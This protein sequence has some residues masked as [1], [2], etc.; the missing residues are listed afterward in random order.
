MMM[1]INMLLIL[2]ICFLL[3]GCFNNRVNEVEPIYGQNDSLDDLFLVEDTNS[4]ITDSIVFAHFNISNDQ[5]YLLKSNFSEMISSLFYY[6]RKAEIFQ[7]EINP[8]ET[9]NT[10]EYGDKTYLIDTLF[11]TLGIKLDTMFLKDNIINLSVEMN[12]KSIVDFNSV[13]ITMINLK[14]KKQFS[15]RTKSF[16]FLNNILND[17]T[18]GWTEGWMIIQH[19]DFYVD[20][21]FYELPQNYII[22]IGQ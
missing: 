16:S 3:Y 12:G 21:M 6:D 14:D 9:I 7:T 13:L 2:A 11:G 22:P 8:V 15:H 18:K 10:N 17:R 20:S 5:K 1:R 4:V 19:L